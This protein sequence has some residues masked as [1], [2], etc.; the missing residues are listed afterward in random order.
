MILVPNAGSMVY[1]RKQRHGLR[2]ET[3]G[4]R[5]VPGIDGLVCGG[6]RRGA[7]HAGERSRIV[8]PVTDHA[9]D[10]G[11]QRSEGVDGLVCCGERRGSSA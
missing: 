9:G 2:Q 10:H 7:G 8:G 6:E 4:R 1:S 11:Q 3:E 5:P